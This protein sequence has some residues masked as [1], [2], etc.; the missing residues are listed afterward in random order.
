M[1][2]VA[3]FRDLDNSVKRFDL[4]DG[5]GGVLHLNVWNWAT[6]PIV[7][8][9]LPRDLLPM[10][11]GD[12][13]LQ[14][15]PAAEAMWASAISIAATQFAARA[16]EVEGDAPRLKE[17][18][19]E[20]LLNADGGEG[21][22]PYVLKS[23]QDFL[24]TG[25]GMITEIERT[26]RGPG[27]RIRAIHH[28]DTLRC[29]I[30]GNRDY[31]VA[32]MADD[33]EHLLPWYNVIRLTDM[34]SPR[35][36]HWGAG[37][38]A[39]RR[40]YPA[41]RKLAAIE[42]YLYEKV[43]GQ[44]PLAIHIV[45]GV[46][47]DQI[48]AAVAGAREQ[49]VDRGNMSYMGVVIMS[50]LKGDA[51]V[52]GYQIP[53]AELPD[54]FDRKQEFDIALLT[55]ADAI[56]LDPQDLQP[57]TGQQLG[58]GAQSVVLAQKASGRG[59][60]TF[61]QALTHKLNE[62]ALA[63]SVKMTFVERNLTDLKAESEIKAAEAGLVTGLA[64]AGLIDSSTATQMLVDADIVPKTALPEG[65]T[66][67]DALSDTD[68]PSAED[69]MTSDELPVALKA[70]RAP[71]AVM[72]AGHTGVMVALPV[73]E[74]LAQQ[75]A[76]LDGVTEPPEQLHLTLA[77]LG[78]SASS[79]LS[80]RLAEAL[81]VVERWA[82]QVAGPITG[83]I[84]GAGRFFGSEGDGTNAVYLSPDLPSLP[85]ARQALC[86]ALEAAGLPPIQNHGYTPHI[87][88]AYVDAD[89]PT[90]D[91]RPEPWPVRF[92]R[93]LLAWGD[94][95]YSVPIGRTA[96]AKAADEVDDL[97]AQEMAAARRLA[98]AARRQL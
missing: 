54:G 4:A 42:G 43:T 44:R 7:P 93:V 38:C 92:D 31:P 50:T 95:W 24:C 97:L 61:E 78:D 66:T 88:V 67:P 59:M 65:D 79:A 29:R 35:R 27:A 82:A 74:V 21:W 70:V 81:A 6:G 20:M 63:A 91:L 94:A 15:T 84:N 87:T 39:A 56:G 98:T 89:A 62:L 2:D 13:V 96:R 37:F 32:Y 80:S 36:D 14:A 69:G 34:P 17:R 19:Q 25:N 33:G 10:P 45:N 49:Q 83:E 22:V 86:A 28:L 52:E 30:T 57:M 41:I 48:N 68:K 8:Q 16:F 76:A 1:T 75:I 51:K 90:P 47:T 23:V 53:L 9:V 64:A 11:Q 72:D 60:R 26:A 18:T 5:S 40:A 55:Y 3:Q 58:A 12:A 85:G 46:R 77:Y 71:D 73:P